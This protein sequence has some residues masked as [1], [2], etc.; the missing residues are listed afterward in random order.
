MSTSKLLHECGFAVTV[1]LLSVVIL[2]E[3]AD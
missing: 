1:S 2:I 3:T